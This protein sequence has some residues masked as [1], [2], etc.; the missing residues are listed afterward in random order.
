[1]RQAF[2]QIKL[3]KILQKVRLSKI[4]KLQQICNN[5][6]KNTKDLTLNFPTNGVD[7]R[8]HIIVFQVPMY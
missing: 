8:R 7:V 4:L 3:K 1:M 2:N 5:N 6:K